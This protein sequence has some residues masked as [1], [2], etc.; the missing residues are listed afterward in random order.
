MASLN[1]VQ[2]VGAQAITGA[3]RMVAAAVA[4]IEASI[5]TVRERHA[6]RA[7]KMWVDLHTLPTTNPLS[8]L[9]TIVCRRFT[10]P[11]QKVAQAHEDVPR[12]GVEMVHGYVISPWE[13]RVPAIIDTDCE[14]AVD[15]ARHT[16]SIRITM[17]SSLR[18]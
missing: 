17:S 1:R 3:F 7:I 12:G 14:K 13:Q 6:D 8:R 5:R 11:L 16:S 9:S 18:K 10:S 2:R 15:A 4:E